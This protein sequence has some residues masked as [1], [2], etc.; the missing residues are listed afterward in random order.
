M[1][2]PDTK[3][4]LRQGGATES[5][6][7]DKAIMVLFP[8]GF[9]EAVTGCRSPE[10]IYDVVLMD[11]RMPEMDGVTATRLIRSLKGEAASVPII[12]V[13]ANAMTGDRENYLSAGMN[14]YVPKPIQPARLTAALARTCHVH[15]P[16]NQAAGR[17]N[18]A[19]TGSSAADLE[20]LIG[21]VDSLLDGKSA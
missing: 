13:T 6:P 7:S 12:G 21:R 3:R 5:C 1:D 2:G 19:E 4:A 16:L 20:A 8:T 11:V 18:R 14:E 15:C 10:E 17:D 9:L